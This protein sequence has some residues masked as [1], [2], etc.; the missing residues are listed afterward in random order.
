MCQYFSA[1]KTEEKLLWLMDS[2]SHEEIINHYGL[3][4]KT[5]SPDFVRLELLPRDGNIFNHNLDNW[6]LKVDQDLLP[7][8]WDDDMKKVATHEM[9]DA[10]KYHWK[11][12]FIL[13]GMKIDK[14]SD[15]VWYMGGGTISAVCG[16][17]ISEVCGGTISVYDKEYIPL[18]IVDTH[19]PR[20]ILPNEKTIIVAN[21]GWKVEV[22]AEEVE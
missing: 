3:N 4:D 22:I 20:I 11:E 17:T 5:D 13:D 1:V 7:P 15:G 19:N 18:N 9:K 12:R 14:I 2:M 21:K 10:V 8:W 16:G 6:E